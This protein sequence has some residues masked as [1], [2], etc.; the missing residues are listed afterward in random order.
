MPCRQGDD[1][2]STIHRPVLALQKMMIG[3]YY[4]T[5]PPFFAAAVLAL[6]KRVIPAPAECMG[7]ELQ[8]LLMLILSAAHFYAAMMRLDLP[9]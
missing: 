8:V 1:R 6:V 9:R 7:A 5:T 4:Y 2:R 3:R